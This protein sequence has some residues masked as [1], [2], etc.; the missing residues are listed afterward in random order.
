MNGER[1]H[2]VGG[3]VFDMALEKKRKWKKMERLIEVDGMVYLRMDRSF[4]GI[5]L[6]WTVRW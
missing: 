4:A 6:N 2:R 5:K 1:R 3:G